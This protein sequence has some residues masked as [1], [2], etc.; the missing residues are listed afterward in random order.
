MPVGLP[1][2]VPNQQGGPK[3]GGVRPPIQS[4]GKMLDQKKVGRN[5]V[6][7]AKDA[8]PL[9]GNQAKGPLSP[10]SHPRV[11]QP[12]QMGPMSAGTLGPRG[13][14]GAPQPQR[15][16]VP[17]SKNVPRG[18]VPQSKP[19]QS[20]KGKGLPIGSAVTV[21]KGGLKSKPVEK[22]KVT[23]PPAS[24]SSTGSTAQN[25][26]AANPPVNQPREATS[27]NPSSANP[28]VS[29]INNSPINQVKPTKPN[30]QTEPKPKPA[31]QP[32]SNSPPEKISE[33]VVPVEKVPDQKEKNQK[34]EL[35]TPPESLQANTRESF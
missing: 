22:Q 6:G 24:P 1:V 31:V 20:L 5:P 15:G 12:G 32:L 10:I 18:P 25:T 30:N 26:P 7:I 3:P 33:K 13:P 16:P 4:P 14:I 19:F 2:K 28:A 9:T 8:K 34:Q 17:V 21:K 23:G 27:S 29:N 11:K 35:K